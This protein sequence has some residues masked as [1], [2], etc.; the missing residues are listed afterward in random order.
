MEALPAPRPRPSVTTRAGPQRLGGRPRGAGAGAG[1]RAPLSPRKPC[2]RAAFGGASPSHRLRPRPARRLRVPDTAPHPRPPSELLGVDP[3]GG[4]PLHRQGRASPRPRPCG[5]PRERLRNPQWQKLS[6]QAGVERPWGLGSRGSPPH[7]TPPGRAGAG[8]PSRAA[9]AIPPRTSDPEC[10]PLPRLRRSWAPSQ[11]R[12]GKGDPRLWT[13]TL[14]ETESQSGRA[15]FFRVT[16]SPSFNLGGQRRQTPAPRTAGAAAGEGRA[17]EGG[18]TRGKSAAGAG[19]A[20]R[21][22]PCGARTREGHCRRRPLRPDCPR[23]PAPTGRPL[24]GPPGL[25]PRQKPHCGESGVAARSEA[26]PPVLP[27]LPGVGRPRPAGRPC[28]RCCGERL[29]LS[30]GQGPEERPG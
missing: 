5:V 29:R 28:G 12:A 26:G 11:P 30:P 23:G 3:G 15:L 24:P 16:A 8:V 27:P 13:P 1:R 14:A 17:R 20:G 18:R 19:G 22:A 2:P 10:C 4:R 25:P 21:A 9:T 7:S 6:F